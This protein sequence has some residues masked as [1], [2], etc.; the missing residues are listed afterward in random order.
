MKMTA[1]QTEIV[2]CASRAMRCNGNPAYMECGRY[3]Y[4]NANAIASA[5]KKGL[6]MV[7]W[8]C[9]SVYNVYP[10]PYAA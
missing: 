1:K 2:T 7:E 3:K 8:L 5:E 4:F 6:V 9:P 10:L